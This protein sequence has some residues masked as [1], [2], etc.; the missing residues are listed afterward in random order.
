AVALIAATAVAGC[1]NSRARAATSLGGVGTASAPV[2]SPSPEAG[3]P[4]ATSTPTGTHPSKSPSHHPS[5]SASSSAPAPAPTFGTGDCVRY[6]PHTLTT[7]NDGTL[8][9]G[10]T[11]GS[12]AMLIL[13]TAADANLAVQLA[14]N[15]DEQCFIGRDNTFTGNDHYRYIVEYWAGTGV[16]GA[17]LPT[18]DCNR[19]DNTAVSTNNLGTGGYQIVAGAEALLVVQT[20][21]DAAAATALA[22]HYSLQCFIGRGNTRTNRAEYIV[23][24]W[25][26]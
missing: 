11:D 21:A 18:N 4:V 15:Y 20:S 14:R 19:Y 6:N 9:Y 26:N 16:S 12:S 7:V 1:A 13:D 3:R 8:G 24:Y 10:V 23:T 22:Q 25:S 5:S 2:A 17:T